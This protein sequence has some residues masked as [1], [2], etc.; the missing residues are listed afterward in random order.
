MGR[1]TAWRDAADVERVTAA[2]RRLH[3]LD[4][5][6][7]AELSLAAAAEYA[8]D[9]L[10]CLAAVGAYLSVAAEG[11]RR[12]VAQPPEVLHTILVRATRAAALDARGV[13]A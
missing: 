10:P 6:V 9:L 7:P 12:L 13:A 11:R 1:R 4:P 3:E 8:V 2:I 5:A